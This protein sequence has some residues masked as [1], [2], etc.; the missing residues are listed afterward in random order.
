MVTQTSPNRKRLLSLAKEVASSDITRRDFNGLRQSFTLH[1]FR[2][3]LLAKR[4]ETGMPQMTIG[5]S[6]RE[7]ELTH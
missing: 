7:L 2:A 3:L 6:F 1:I 4:N 5:C